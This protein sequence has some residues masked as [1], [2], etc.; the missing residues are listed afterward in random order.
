MRAILTIEYGYSMVYMNS[1]ALQ[2]VIYHRDSKATKPIHAGNEEFLLD[3][4]QGGRTI[5][6]T[7]VDDL[8]PG[9]LMKHIPVKTY[10]RVLAGALFLLKV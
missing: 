9:H 2:A 6:Q 5:L 7:V 4:V 1:V 10:S 3:V 8:L